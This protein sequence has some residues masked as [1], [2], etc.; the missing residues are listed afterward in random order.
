MKKYQYYVYI[1]TNSSRKVL[2]IG[3]TNNV[4]RRVVEHYANRGK[5][6]TFAGRYHCY[7]LVYV[8]EFKYINDAIAREKELKAW[9]REKEEALVDTVNPERRFLNEEYCGE[10]PPG[11]LWKE[12]LDELEGR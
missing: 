6:K 5:S 7:Y 2:Y 9:R 8:E 4:A 3:V 10:W 12:Y 1:I 11:E